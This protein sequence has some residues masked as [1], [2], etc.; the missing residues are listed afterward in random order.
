MNTTR[1]IVGPSLGGILIMK[2]INDLWKSNIL[3][4]V[5]G[6]IIVHTGHCTQNVFFCRRIK[7]GFMAF[8]STVKFM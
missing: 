2:K 4:R 8:V 3:F 1:C 5:L 6:G 7:T